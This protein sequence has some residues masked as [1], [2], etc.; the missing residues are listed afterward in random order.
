ML[1][2]KYEA[3]VDCDAL[4]SFTRTRGCARLCTIAKQ[5]VDC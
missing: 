5:Q 2:V 3:R 1:I 4:L